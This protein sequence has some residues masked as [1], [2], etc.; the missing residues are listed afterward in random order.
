MIT[1]IALL[2]EQLKLPT[3]NIK[4]PPHI[5]PLKRI[6]ILFFGDVGFLLDVDCLF[7]LHLEEGLDLATNVEYLVALLGRG[8]DFGRVD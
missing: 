1:R 7:E 3:A 2:I 4:I 6:I 5:L 8:V